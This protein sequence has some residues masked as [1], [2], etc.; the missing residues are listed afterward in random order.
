MNS[1]P[2]IV[3][4]LIISAI[5]LAGRISPAMSSEQYSAGKYIHI[6]N[7]IMEFNRVNSTVDVEYHL[8]PFTKA[9]IFFFGSKNLEP[10]IKEIFSEFPEVKIQ[11]IGFNSATLQITNISSKNG[12]D[13]MHESTKLGLRP[14]ILTIVYP[15]NQGT[16]EI[17]NPDSTLSVF[18]PVH[19]EN[20]NNTT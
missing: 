10:K 7:I 18:Y 4:V 1:K 8:A 13:Y 5:L 2:I 9:Y 20:Q 3:I 16:R 19:P 15:Y 14:D 11:K 6:D 17:K 12:Q